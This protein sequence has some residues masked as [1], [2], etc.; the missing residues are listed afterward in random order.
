M[1]SQDASKVQMVTVEMVDFTVPV[2]NT[3]TAAIPSQNSFTDGNTINLYNL[4][5]SKISLKVSSLGGTKVLT[6]VAGVNVTGGGNVTQ[7]NVYT[8]TWTNASVKNGYQIV[9]AD[10]TDPTKTTTINVNIL[11]GTIT[12]TDATV[13]AANSGDT[14]IPV[15]SP[16]CRA[17]VTSWGGGSEWFTIKTNPSVGSSNLVISQVNNVSNTM[18]PATITLTNSVDGGANATV[19]VTPTGFVVPALT[20][21]SAAINNFYL[22]IEQSATFTAAAPGGIT[23]AISSNPAVATVS[24]NGNTFK[25]TAVNLGTANITVS[26]KSAT[27]STSTYKITVA[28][29]KNYVGK[30]V[31]NYG[32]YIAPE[33]AAKVLWN[34]NLTRDYCSNKSGATWYVPTEDEWLAIIKKPGGKE[35]SS[36]GV[37]YEYEYYWASNDESLM[38]FTALD[39][40]VGNGTTTVL[41]TVRCIAK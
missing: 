25:V 1:N 40:Y 12:A 13:T 10:F 7:D 23:D 22:N 20:P 27:G 15:I 17:S 14:S 16:G 19:T 3:P 36:K 28:S 32:F 24:R 37:L 38:Y 26:N 30:A 34:A 4:S 39:P 35:L 5:G 9:I 31:W 11:N 21:T 2:V 41:Q 8:F 29:P 33:N 18:K 6:P